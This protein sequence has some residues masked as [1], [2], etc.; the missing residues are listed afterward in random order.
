MIRRHDWATPG[1]CMTCLHPPHAT[2]GAPGGGCSLMLHDG[3]AMMGGMPPSPNAPTPELACGC[4]FPTSFS[5]GIA[6]TWWHPPHTAS[7]APGGCCSTA[8]QSGH[9]T[10]LVKAWAP[11]GCAGAPFPPETTGEMACPQ[12]PHATV[13]TPGGMSSWDAHLGHVAMRLP[14]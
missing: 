3:H 5:P 2:S 11:G 10:I 6:M 8:A 14:P 7:D 12:E 1:T 9:L 13:G 4:A